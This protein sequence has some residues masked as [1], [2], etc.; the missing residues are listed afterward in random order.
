M[1]KEKKEER[2]VINRKERIAS[3]EDEILF[4]ESDL[5]ELKLKILS[6][7]ELLEELIEKEKQDN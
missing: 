5:Q 2:F 1:V 7:K 6:R 4:L 3:L